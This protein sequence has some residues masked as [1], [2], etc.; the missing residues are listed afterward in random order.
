MVEARLALRRRAEVFD[1][2]D[3]R[4][5]AAVCGRLDPPLESKARLAHLAFTKQ[6]APLAIDADSHEISR[7]E[8]Q[9]AVKR[10]AVGGLAN[11]LEA[12]GDQE[13]RKQAIEAA[14]FVGMRVVP[15]RVA[16]LGGAYPSNML[17]APQQSADIQRA[18]DQHR[19]GK[20][21]FGCE[22]DR[23]CAIDLDLA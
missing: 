9:A 17:A 13:S 16:E 21:A 12:A 1:D 11:V 6:D 2:L 14:A 22:F 3:D 18:V 8:R 23:A 5:A 10:M 19:E 7:R 4:K 15:G 20:P